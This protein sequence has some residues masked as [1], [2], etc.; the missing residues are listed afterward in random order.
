MH[1]KLARLLRIAVI[2][3]IFPWVTVTAPGHAAAGSFADVSDKTTEFPAVEFLKAKGIMQ[4]YP[5]GTFKPNQKVTRAEAVK[6]LVASKLSPDEIA[7]YSKTS[8]TDVP[9]DVWYRPYVEAALNKLGIIDG[10]P[11]ATTFNGTRTV[12]RAEFLK[13]LFKSQDIDTNAY[14]EIKLPLAKDVSNPDEWYY[15]Y[16][17]Y[18]VATM[19]IQVGTDGMLRPDLELTRGELALEVYYLAMYQAGKRTQAGLSTEESDLV[20]T[21]QL[22][23]G[24]DIEGANMASARALLAARGALTS[25]PTTGIVQAAV[26]IAEAFRSLVRGYRAGTEGKLQDVIDRSKEA[27]TYAETAKQLS[28]SLNELAGSVQ[29]IAKTM[30]DQAREMLKGGAPAS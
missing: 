26:K 29:T 28:P 8:Y 2:I 5:D 25:K 12:R 6:I 15:P 17:R 30:A 22:L 9:A 18:A 24:K 19:V 14:G 10:P 21:L 27:Y 16:M 3:I 7:T 23:E 20:N 13:L 1:Q 11:K 4:G